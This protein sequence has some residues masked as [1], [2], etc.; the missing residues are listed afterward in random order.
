MGDTSDNYPGVQGIGP[1]TALKLF[2]QFGS[3]EGLI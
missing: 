1:K 2:D 3:I